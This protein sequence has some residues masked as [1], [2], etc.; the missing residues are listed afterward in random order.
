MMW[1]QGF[2]I[3]MKIISDSP[4]DAFYSDTGVNLH[5]SDTD[6]TLYAD[7]FWYVWVDSAWCETRAHIKLALSLL[8]FTNTLN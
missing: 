3:A 4:E 8:Y 6:W 7:T 1:D 2:S 5:A